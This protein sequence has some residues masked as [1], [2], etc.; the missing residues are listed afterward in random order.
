[1]ELLI[2]ILLRIFITPI[3]TLLSLPFLLIIALWD[4]K[5]Y[6]KKVGELI[7]FVFK[8]LNSVNI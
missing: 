2:E 1:M 5:R 8:K 6:W 7:K 3:L 4:F